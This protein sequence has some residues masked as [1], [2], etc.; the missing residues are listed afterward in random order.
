MRGGGGKMKTL[1]GGGNTLR[2]QCPNRSKEGNRSRSKILDLVP[3]SGAKKL[4]GRKKKRLAKMGG[5]TLP[6]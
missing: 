4:K 2:K 3:K 6:R 1:R 5:G